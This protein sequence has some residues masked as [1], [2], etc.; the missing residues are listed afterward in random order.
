MSEI[1]DLPEERL[2]A[3]LRTQAEGFLPGEAA[4]ELLIESGW[5]RQGDLRRFIDYAPDP[6]VTGAPS[7]AHAGYIVD[8]VRRATGTSQL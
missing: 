2:A 1:H 4:A 5:L 3:A 6:A 8:A 7:H